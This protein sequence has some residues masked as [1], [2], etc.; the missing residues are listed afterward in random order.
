MYRI[1]LDVGNETAQ[2]AS[3]EIDLFLRFESERMAGDKAN[4]EGHRTASSGYV[5]LRRIRD[6]IRRETERRARE[7]REAKTRAALRGPSVREL[8]KAG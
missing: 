3:H 7:D 2:N 6:Q 4:P 1:E 5:L 8:R